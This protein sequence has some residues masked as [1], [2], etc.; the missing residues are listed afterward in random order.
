MSDAG[1]IV[2]TEGV[3]GRPMRLP[4]PV[5]RGSAR[6]IYPVSGLRESLRSEQVSEKGA[7]V[8]EDRAQPQSGQENPPGSMVQKLTR[9]DPCP[10]PA[11]VVPFGRTECCKT[12]MLDGSDCLTDAV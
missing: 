4:V 8:C 12:L 3:L 6:V 11:L 1:Q 5:G 7:A 9:A 10:T 2:A